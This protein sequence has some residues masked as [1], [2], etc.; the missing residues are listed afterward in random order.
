[1]QSTTH[2]TAS[3]LT[4]LAFADLQ[5]FFRTGTKGH[6]PSPLMLDG[7]FNLQDTLS[8][9]VTGECAP[10]V[11]VSSLDPG[12]GKTS[13]I[14]AWL[15]VY[16]NARE[17]YGDKGIILCFDRLEE[18]KQFLES[19]PLATE[20][21]G[22]YVNTTSPEGK[23][24][25]SMGVGADKV[26]EAPVL[27]TTKAM[28]ISRAK[29]GKLFKSLSEFHYKG[30]PREIRIWDESMIIGRPLL[31]TLGQILKLH[32]DLEIEAPDLAQM[33]LDLS[34]ILR[35]CKDRDRI[36][37][38]DLGGLEFAQ[39]F[40]WDGALTRKTAETLS[41]LSGRPVTVRIE[42]K[43][44]V[45]LD[46]VASL[47]DDFF[48]CLVTDASARIR[49]T[50]SLLQH[51][52]GNVTYLTPKGS[53]K[54]YHPLTI[55]IWD[56]SSSKQHYQKNGMDQTAHEIAKVIQSRPG[57]GFL[58]VTVRGGEKEIIKK[59]WIKTIKSHLPPEDHSRLHFLT[60]GRH[61]AQNAYADIPNVI[62]TSQLYY[63]TSEYEA[64]GRASANLP[65]S[66]GTLTE[67][68]LKNFRKGEVAHHLLQCICRGRVRVAIGD[69][70]PPSRCWVIASK[71]TGIG[72]MLSEIFPGCTVTEWDTKMS[73]KREVNEA[74][75]KALTFILETLK[76]GDVKS[77]KLVS[78]LRDHMGYDSREKSNF[79]QRFLEN[80]KFKDLCG[81]HGLHVYKNETNG[82]WIIEEHPFSKGDD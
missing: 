31:V 59:R 14:K 61:T 11:Y 67:E 47:P 15:R 53:C 45:A 20:E 2:L 62:L 46:C 54:S 8:K 12:V 21:F 17:E 25:N 68:Q 5:K 81:D 48:P 82:R 36:E 44:R 9:M 56:R 34:D 30:V 76:A 16:L 49:E 60:W 4:L 57:E 33:I 65:T 23:E 72:S 13:A 32:G 29:D 66:Q 79:R 74:H 1:M 27:F 71:E 10:E 41:L 35:R 70:C 80:A 43:G 69:A 38:P 63:K 58:I 28:I 64:N 39:G 77:A 52:Q 24:L 40:R 18:I 22:A 51:Y 6:D 3:T 26:S 75:Q 73:P 42:G 37:I 78:Q 19:K 7:L 55:N 50:Y